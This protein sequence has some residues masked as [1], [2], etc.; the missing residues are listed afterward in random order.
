[1]AP[2]KR[3]PHVKG[4]IN[5]K[6][7]KL[8]DDIKKL[9]NKRQ[10][11]LEGM[12]KKRLY[13]TEEVCI[14]LGVKTSTVRRSIAAGR[15]KGI[16][17]GRYLRIPSEEVERLLQGSE[18]LF[19]AREA[20]QLLNVGPG[21]IRALIN[22]GKMKASRLTPTGPFMITKKEVERIASYGIPK[23]KRQRHKRK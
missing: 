3:A 12:M 8:A 16:H 18:I 6:L 4:S 9:P 15:I 1:M 11:L 17:V 22:T 14:I 7:D 13:N 23:E 5:E 2:R 19:N 21:T 20:G 10:E